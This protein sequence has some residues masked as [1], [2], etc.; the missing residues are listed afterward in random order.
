[1]IHQRDGQTDR[2][3]DGRTDDMQS[4]YRALH[5]SASRGKKLHRTIAIHCT[6]LNCIF[7]S[8][9][10]DSGAAFSVS[11]RLSS[12]PQE[13]TLSISDVFVITAHCC[14]L[15]G[16]HHQAIFVVDVLLRLHSHVLLPGV[17]AMHY[18]TR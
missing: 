17:D 8:H 11:S 14:R 18:V 3:A 5:Y 15:R 16:R 2:Q 6:L 4:Q 1:M 10:I 13:A 7:I 12:R 9:F